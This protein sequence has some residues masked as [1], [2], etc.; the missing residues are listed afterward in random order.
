MK[1]QFTFFLLI[2]VN[3][4]GLSEEFSYVY[5]ENKQ[6]NIKT[7]KQATFIPFILAINQGSKNGLY[8]IKIKPNINGKNIIQLNNNHITD[9]K[10]YS[11]GK[12]LSDIPSHRFTTYDFSAQTDSIYLR[13][14]A[15][16]E[17]FIPIKSYSHENF[18]KQEQSQ[19]LIVGLFYGFALMVIVVNLFYYFNFQD[20]SFLYYAL[21]LISVG[22]TFSHRDG[23]IQ[24]LGVP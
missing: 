5:D 7:I 15:K 9:V 16:K 14:D 10:A 1:F 22:I 11:N 2:L 8:W 18:L 6:F 23:F 17:A 12:Q 20:K 3:Q 24:I 4:I 13:I 19:M 21:F